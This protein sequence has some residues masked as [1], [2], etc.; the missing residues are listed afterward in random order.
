M[1][2]AKDRDFA[3]VGVKCN[4]GVKRSISPDLLVLDMARTPMI[5]FG[6]ISLDLLVSSPY[7]I[8]RLN[9]V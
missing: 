5:F 6:G 2:N 4:S 7:H 8:N 1:L 9:T 3:D